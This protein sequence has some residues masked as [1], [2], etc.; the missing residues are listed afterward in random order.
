MTFGLENASFTLPEWQAVK[1][2]F[3][4]PWIG[5]QCVPSNNSISHCRTHFSPSPLLVSKVVNWPGKVPDLWYN[6]VSNGLA[7]ILLSEP[8]ELEPRVSPL[9]SFGVLFT[10]A[11]PLCFIVCFLIVCYLKGPGKDKSEKEVG[12][13]GHLIESVS[14]ILDTAFIDTKNTNGKNKEKKTSVKTSNG[15]IEEDEPTDCMV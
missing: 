10:M 15:T 2:T 8:F 3:F 4:A 6:K 7:F 12:V 1:M 14:P 5:D 9:A 11:I 13:S